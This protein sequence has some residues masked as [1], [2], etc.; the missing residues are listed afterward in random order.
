MCRRKKKTELY[1]PFADDFFSF[2]LFFFATHGQPLQAHSVPRPGLRGRV[3]H[4]AGEGH[5]GPRAAISRGSAAAQD[6]GRAQDRQ[7]AHAA[8]QFQLH[9][10][11]ARRGACGEGEGPAE[12]AGA[13]LGV[14]LAGV[15]RELGAGLVEISKFPPPQIEEIDVK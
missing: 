10:R 5:P 12:G 9:L 2:F 13:D 8:V 11:R 6:R 3:H 7:K 14:R 4:E 15:E 1:F